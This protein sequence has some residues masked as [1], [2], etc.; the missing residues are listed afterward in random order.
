MILASQLQFAPYR[1]NPY[2]LRVINDFCGLESRG[3]IIRGQSISV[4]IT[5][6]LSPY[7]DTFKCHVLKYGDMRFNIGTQAS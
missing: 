5:G 1:S 3:R 7:T 2:R 6:K 4:T